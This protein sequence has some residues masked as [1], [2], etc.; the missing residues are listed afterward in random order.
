MESLE[1]TPTPAH[2]TG[3]ELQRLMTGGLSP[4]DA[5]VVVRHLLKGCSTCTGETRKMWSFG[6]FGSRGKATGEQADSCVSLAVP[7]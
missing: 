2:P 5:K 6:E 3:E 4:V 1:S 7:L